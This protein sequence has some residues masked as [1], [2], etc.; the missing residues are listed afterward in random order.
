M[1]GMA[2]GQEHGRNIR[3][4]TSDPGQKP[5]QSTARKPS[6]HEEAL[7]AGLQISCVA[8]AAA[9]KDAKAQNRL[10]VYVPVNNFGRPG[11]PLTRNLSIQHKAG[12]SPWM[13]QGFRIAVES[14]CGGQEATIPASGGR[15]FDTPR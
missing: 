2:M 14:D 3:K 6:V 8:R 10:Q 1:I 11:P 4:V 9:R 15:G 5:S 7:P 12:R 13:I